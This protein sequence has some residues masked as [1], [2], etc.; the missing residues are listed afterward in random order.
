MQNRLCPHGAF[1]LLMT[2]DIKQTVTKINIKL[3]VVKSVMKEK[4]KV[5]KAQSRAS[6]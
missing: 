6:I 3:Q 4:C 5:C 1:S 2:M